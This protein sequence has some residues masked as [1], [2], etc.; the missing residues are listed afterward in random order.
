MVFSFIMVSFASVLSYAAE[1]LSTTTI[2]I[3]ISCVIIIILLII[4]QTVKPDV[5]TIY[6]MGSSFI[7]AGLVIYLIVILIS[8]LNFSF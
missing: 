7:S 8:M 1:E 6:A 4:R 3:S 2:V 5:K